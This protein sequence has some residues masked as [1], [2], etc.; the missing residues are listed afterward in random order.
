MN[1]FEAVKEKLTAELAA[2]ISAELLSMGEDIKGLSWFSSVAQE[3]NR[4]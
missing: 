3:Y 1:S 4:N 2:V